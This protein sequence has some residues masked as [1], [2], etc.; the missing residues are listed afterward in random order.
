MGSPGAGKT[1]VGKLLAQSL[2]KD[3]IDVDNDHLEKVWRMPVA[4]KVYFILN[5]LYSFLTDSIPVRSL[6][7]FVSLMALN[8]HQAFQLSKNLSVEKSKNYDSCFSPVLEAI[9]TL[10]WLPRTS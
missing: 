10:L 6:F 5:S 1:T 7:Q 4:E 2:G 3:A 9:V 8:Y